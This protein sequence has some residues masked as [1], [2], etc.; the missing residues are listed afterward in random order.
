MTI[1]AENHLAMKTFWMWTLLVL[2]TSVLHAQ[3]LDYVPAYQ[4]AVSLQPFAFF[5]SG[6]EASIERR[7][8]PMAS[9]MFTAGYYLSDRPSVYDEADVMQGLKLELQP[10]F[11]VNGEPLNG[12][13]FAPYLLYRQIRLENYTTFMF[14]PVTGQGR[15]TDQNLSA[16]AG[17]LGAVFGVSTL[18]GTRLSVGVYGGG[19]LIIPLSDYD[20]DTFHIP[21]ANPYLRG[22]V[23]RAGMSIG[24]AF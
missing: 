1:F 6:L 18:V 12:V 4:T 3:D 16:K 2:S 22:I 13:Y 9:L 21:L 20:G 23:P 15:S 10:R 8:A 11:Y 24:I 7:I 17:G 14:D 5:G 19:G